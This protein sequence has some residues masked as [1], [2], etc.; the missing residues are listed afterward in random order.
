MKKLMI[1][2]MAAALCG[3]IV[4]H[5]NDGGESNLAVNVVKDAVHEKLSVGDERVEGECTVRSILGFITWGDEK[6]AADQSEFDGYG[7]LARAK[8]GAYAD[9]CEKADCDQIAA[10]RYTVTA[11]HAFLYVSA[12]AKVSGYPVKVE[13]VEIVPPPTCGCCTK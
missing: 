5:K 8:H 13:S 9:A 1:V 11:F 7:A 2:A 4:V 12:N 10:T 3:C 6:H